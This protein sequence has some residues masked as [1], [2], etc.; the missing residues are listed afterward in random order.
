MEQA[1]PYPYLRRSLW[2]ANMPTA[3]AR[4]TELVDRLSIKLYGSELWVVMANCDEAHDIFLQAI[5]AAENCAIERAAQLI[6]RLATTGTTQITPT[7]AADLIR[8]LKDENAVS[9]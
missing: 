5:S 6:G 1:V 8:S 3:S 9:E 7:A 4:A 2:N